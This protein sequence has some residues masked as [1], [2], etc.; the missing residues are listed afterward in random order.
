MKV[1][2]HV[3]PTMETFVKNIL[4]MVNMPAYGSNMLNFY[5]IG[6][7]RRWRSS[8]GVDLWD[9]HGYYDFTVGFNGDSTK[10]CQ[11]QTLLV[12][13]DICELY[14]EV[15]IEWETTIGEIMEA[16]G[17]RKYWPGC[18]STLCSLIAQTYLWSLDRPIAAQHLQDFV[19]AVT[20]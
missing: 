6:D 19:I 20:E 11:Y 10:P 2:H 18:V 12:R 15:R 13:L 16:Q 14:H 1:L 5:P 8:F 9:E 17:L 4:E 3:P 7:G